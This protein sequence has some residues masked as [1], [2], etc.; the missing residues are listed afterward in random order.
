MT[1]RTIEELARQARFWEFI[2]NLSQKLKEQK[3]STENILQSR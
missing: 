2:Q 1:G 3:V